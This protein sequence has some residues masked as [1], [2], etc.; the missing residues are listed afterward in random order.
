MS[1]IEQLSLNFEVSPD[2]VSQLT[3]GQGHMGAVSE[4]KILRMPSRIDR[5][6]KQASERE[7]RL[8]ERVLRRA[9][10]F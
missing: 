9:Y 7:A 3:D 5:A 8:L 1:R 6:D 4:A 2:P 10:Y